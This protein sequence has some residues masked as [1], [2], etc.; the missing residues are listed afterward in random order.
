[1]YD[2]CF[3][4]AD[5]SQIKD[6]VN[7]AGIAEGLQQYLQTTTPTA[8]NGVT[9]APT[10]GPT[11]GLSS[12]QNNQP[13]SSST[14]AQGPTPNTVNYGTPPFVYFTSPAA[15]AEIPEV[16]EVGPVPVSNSMGQGGNVPASVPA[17]E[18]PA[19]KLRKKRGPAK[20]S[21]TATTPAT[22][23]PKRRGRKRKYPVAPPVQPE[24]SSNTNNNTVN[25]NPTFESPASTD[26][27]SNEIPVINLVS[28]PVS[29]SSTSPANNNGSDNN[30]HSLNININNNPDDNDNN[31]G[32][33]PE[34]CA[35]DL[36]TFIPGQ[37]VQDSTSE[38][39]FSTIATSEE[40]T[41]DVP[42]SY[43]GHYE[44]ET[45]AAVIEKEV[46]NA[47]KSFSKQP[48]TCLDL[49]AAVSSAIQHG[50]LNNLTAPTATSESEIPSSVENSNDCVIS[51]GYMEQR[52][53]NGTNTAVDNEIIEHQHQ[54]S[55]PSPTPNTFQDQQFD[56]RYHAQYSETLNMETNLCDSNP[57]VSSSSTE[58]THNNILVFQRENNSSNFKVFVNGLNEHDQQVNRGYPNH[59]DSRDDR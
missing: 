55:S 47:E 26:I 22:G 48:V 8:T 4:L 35:S 17:T 13:L 42:E 16:Y 37:T 19:V 46:K 33:E 53:W 20:K 18:E 57:S 1:M 28:P 49:L 59:S 6:L 36:Q 34:K 32:I 43:A 56:Q 3:L 12:A 24:P 21:L 14:V 44:Q 52:M 45:P 41:S 38:A 58:D 39:Q 10:I 5:Y 27:N 31:N 51:N 29:E 54:I 50:T 30:G 11:P 40:A 15:A 9:M 25:V 23:S 2:L 7:T